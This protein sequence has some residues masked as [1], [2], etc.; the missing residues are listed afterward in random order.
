MS[1]EDRQKVAKKSRIYPTIALIIMLMAV[2]FAIL[3]KTVS[4]TIVSINVSS[5]EELAEHDMNAVMNSLNE[6][7]NDMTATADDIRTADFDSIE[8]MISMLAFGDDYVDCKL[9]ALTGDDGKVYRS[10]GVIGLEADS[11]LYDEVVQHDD[12]FAVRFDYTSGVQIETNKEYILIGIPITPFSVEGVAFDHLFALTPIKSIEKEMIVDSYDGQGTG[13]I[14]DQDGYYVVNN[15]RSHNFTVRNNYFDDIKQAQIDGY[16]SPDELIAEITSGVP[17]ISVEFSYNNSDFIVILKKMEYSSWY[18][19]SYVPAEVFQAQTNRI[20][21][22]FGIVVAVMAVA[23]ISALAMFL[24]MQ[25]KKAQMANAHRAELSEALALAQQANRAKTTFLNNMSHDIRTPMNAIIGFTALATTHADEPDTVRGYLGKITQSSEH[26][27]SL[28]NDVLDMSRI[29]SGKVNI[30]EKPENLAEILHSLRDMFQSDIHSKQM[31]FYMDTV[32]VVDEDII[33]D[34][35]RLNQVLLNI[36][37]NALKYT[38]PGGTVSLRVVEKE[39]KDSG[40][41]TYEFRVKDNGIGMSEEFAQTVFEPFTREETSTVSGIQGT[42]LGMAIT[43]NIVE[44]MGGSVEVHSRLHEGTEVVITL[45]FKLAEKHRRIEKIAKL[46]GLRGLVVDDDINTCQS[47]AAMLRTIGMRPE[48]CTFGKEAIVRTEE[49]IRIGDSF[50][51]YVIDWLM[52]DMNG[53]ETARRIRRV[54][55]SEAPIIILTAYDWKDIEDEAREAGVTGFVNKPLFPSDLR[56]VLMEVCGEV[57]E[58]ENNGAS[59]KPGVSSSEFTGS[60]V[61]LAEDNELNREIAAE[62]LGEA[63]FTVE[64]AENGRKCIDML[65]EKPENYYD[66]ILMDIQMPVMDGY[67]AAREI[68]RLDSPAK[69]GIPILALSANTFAEDIKASEEAGMNGHISKPIRIPV[70]IAELERVL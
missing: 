62:V 3:Y 20:L 29:E 65:V 61:L 16:S 5:M 48:W 69:A 30:S 60:R 46:D 27:L 47:V 11:I 1:E 25:K 67:Q 23:V 8:D 58:T 38:A 17:T 39:I 36:T 31:N 12:K 19:A 6:R 63:G 22:I 24:N 35:L 42:G 33:C 53:I 44:M 45:D 64:T 57:I 66:V 51:V 14:I 26:L 4:N 56:R 10:T 68:R 49:A 7:W 55:G 18:Y 2:A 50:T 59:G 34:K 43:K 13:Y 41:A 21:S 9:L 15:N 37:S 28:I 70:L 54:V 52:P 32:D 40:Y